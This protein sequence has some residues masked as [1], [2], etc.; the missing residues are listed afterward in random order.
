MGIAIRMASQV[1]QARTRPDR[2]SAAATLIMWF[3][4]G[5]FVTSTL[6]LYTPLLSHGLVTDV[7]GGIVTA[8]AV[9]LFKA[10]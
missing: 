1:F 6:T 4:A 7:V 3:A 2:V 5:A 9:L 10:A 8:A